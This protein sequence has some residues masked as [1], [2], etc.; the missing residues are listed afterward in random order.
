MILISVD[1]HI[2]EP[3]DC[4][5]STSPAKYKDIAPRI[6]HMPDGTD[7]WIFLDFDI[8]NVGLNAVTGRPPEEYGLDPTSFDELRPGTYDVEAARARHVG[9]RRARFAQLPVAARLRGTPVRRARRQG[10]RARAVP[11]VQRLAHR[12]V[13]RRR[14]RPLHP[15]RDPA[16]LGSRRARRRSAPRRR[17]GLPRDHVPGEP[18]A[19]R[20]AEPAHRPLGS[21]LEGVQRRRHDRQHAHRFVVEARDHRDGRAGR[22]DDDAVSR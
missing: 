13:V 11:R 4:S 22:R 20:A 9:E 10:R 21:V 16:D 6:E 8:P 12:R 7:R 2:V 19:A 17:E 18:G 15:A 3:P 5:R 14:A 1:D